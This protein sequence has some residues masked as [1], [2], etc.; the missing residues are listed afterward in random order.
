MN[1]ISVTIKTDKNKSTKVLFSD[2]V[3]NAQGQLVLLIKSVNS[4]NY[5]NGF[6]LTEESTPPPPPPGTK[7]LKV[8][9]FGGVNPYSNAEWNNW[10][11]AASLSTETLKYSDATLSPIVAVLS[12]HSAIHDNG[13]T[14]GGSM[15]PPEV[16][17]YASSSATARTLTLSGLSTG[18]TFNLDLYASR[19]A[20]SGYVTTFTAGGIVQN[21]STY[22]NKS[23]KA[24]F[25][26]LEPT[27]SGQIVVSIASSNAYNYLNGFILTENPGSAATT[28]TVS[29]H[30]GSGEKVLSKSAF[31]LE[32][33]PNPS[34]G[35]FTLS[36]KSFNE[37]PVFVTVRDGVGRVVERKQYLQA[38]GTVPLGQTYRPGIY[39]AEVVQGNQRK[40]V[41]LVKTAKSPY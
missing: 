13:T 30:A 25:T 37:T 7:T 33:F 6:V 2:L 1:E 15:A 27:A 9:L 16:L 34:P 26:N 17:R 18:K 36:I 29:Q 4:Y 14:Y 11:V 31:E 3:P 41:K 21:I 28:L 10:N 5:L 38:H 24:S 8:N 20:N 39:Y 12:K 40:T 32:A 23:L 35:I 19:N 22:Q